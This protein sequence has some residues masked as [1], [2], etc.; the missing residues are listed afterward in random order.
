MSEAHALAVDT[1]VPFDERSLYL[2]RL[3]VDGLKGGQRGHLGSALSLI[4]ILR[5]LYDEVLDVDPARPDW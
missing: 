2:R 4:E 3:V 5:V 1:D